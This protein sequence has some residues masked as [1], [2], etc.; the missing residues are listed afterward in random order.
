MLSR[1][2]TMFPNYQDC[3]TRLNT[4]VDFV[5]HHDIAA[6]NAAVD[7]PL[8]P[9]KYSCL[10]QHQAGKFPMNMSIV[11]FL[12]LSDW[13]LWNAC[14]LIAITAN[15]ELALPHERTKRK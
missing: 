9:I 15:P 12:E 7:D 2:K 13:L 14:E 1:T 4:L 11:T 8:F 5:F 3:P 10:I 6:A